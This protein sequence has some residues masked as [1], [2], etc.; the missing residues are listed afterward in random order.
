MSIGRADDRC[1][2]VLLIQ[3]ATV[4]AFEGPDGE[5]LASAFGRR[6]AERRERRPGIVLWHALIVAFA[7][8]PSHP[9]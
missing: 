1:D 2:G 4:A 5:R 9:A 6:R 7:A 3:G 8:M